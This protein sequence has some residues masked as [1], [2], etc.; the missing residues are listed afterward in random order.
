MQ[1]NPSQ[2]GSHTRAC[3]Y[4]DGCN[5]YNGL[6]TGQLRRYYWLDLV[7]LGQEF[8]KPGQLLTSTKYFTARVVGDQD[9]N[10]RHSTYIDA[11]KAGGVE[12]IEGHFQ[13]EPFYCARCQNR[14]Q[15]P[16]E[17]QTDTN[18]AT[19]MVADAFLG[20]WDVAFLVSGDA[21]LVPPIPLRPRAVPGQ[22]GA[23]RV[24]TLPHVA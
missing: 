12:V 24:P 15:V 7:R 22:A 23:G 5:L 19:A 13:L 8:L 20:R 9:K 2:S 4:V 16:K 17:K 6:R 18:I 11:L 1:Q 3:L 14:R 21:D 10:R